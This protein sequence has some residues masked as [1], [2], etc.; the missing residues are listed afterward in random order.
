[1]IV[2][3]SLEEQFPSETY[4]HMHYNAL[5]KFKDDKEPLQLV[6]VPQHDQCVIAM[7]PANG[8]V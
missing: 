7:E 8:K 4:K 1:M 2:I 5:F 6:I 3:Q